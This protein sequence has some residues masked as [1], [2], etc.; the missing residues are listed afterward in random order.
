MDSD[1]VCWKLK[2]L[3]R[4]ALILPIRKNFARNIME[5]LAHVLIAF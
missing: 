4:R 2:I 5:H 3:P 1:V